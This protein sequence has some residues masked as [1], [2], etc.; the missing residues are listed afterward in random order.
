MFQPFAWYLAAA[1]G[2]SEYLNAVQ[3]QTVFTEGKDVRIPPDRNYYLG[4]LTVNE[5]NDVNFAALEAP[6]LRPLSNQYISRAVNQ[7]SIALTSWPIDYQFLSPRQ[8]RVTES[9]QY[10]INETGG[11]ATDLYG[12]VWMGDGPQQDV[13]GE[14]FSTRLTAAVQQVEGAWTAGNMVFT[15]ALPVTDYQVVGMRVEAATG[16]A[17]RL[18]FS[19]SEIRPGTIMHN[20]VGDIDAQ[21]FRKG[22]S[23]VWGQFDINQPPRLEVLGGTAAV[24]NVYLDLIRTG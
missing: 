20:V 16:V 21:M 7:A 14:I 4:G 17:A 8:L 15:E 19:N 12:V 11:A 1:A 13:S 10:L 2:G 6:S 22:R 23:G 9:M 24:Q 18:I 3:D 5:I